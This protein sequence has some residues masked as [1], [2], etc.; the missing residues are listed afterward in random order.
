MAETPQHV[1]EEN[2]QRAAL[3]G[4]KLRWVLTVKR[5]ANGDNTPNGFIATSD[6]FLPIATVMCHAATLP[7]LQHEVEAHLAALWQASF[8]EGPLPRFPTI[9]FQF[10]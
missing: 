1:G 10:Q 5:H 8:K 9:V 2:W 6:A 4:E 7:A 3:A